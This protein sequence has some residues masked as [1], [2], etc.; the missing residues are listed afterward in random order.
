M[1]HC[2]AGLLS[3]VTLPLQSPLMRQTLMDVSLG[4]MATAGSACFSE[5]RTQRS[6]LTVP[7]DARD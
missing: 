5:A 1:L 2:D 3:M 6:Q 4:A 7:R